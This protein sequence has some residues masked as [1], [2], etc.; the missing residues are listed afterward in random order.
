MG[1]G[2]RWHTH[3]KY[4]FLAA[5]YAGIVVI[6]GLV[7]AMLYR[8]RV[9]VYPV[10]FAAAL[11]FVLHPVA[12]WLTRHR[13][14]RSV[15][16]AIVVFLALVAAIALGFLIVPMLIVR[17]SEVIER[18]PAMVRT[19]Q[20]AVGPFLQ[21]NLGVEL[22]ADPAAI[23]AAVQEHL[24]ELAKPSGWLISNIFRSA[25][26]IGLA[27][28][29]VVITVVFTFYIVRNHDDIGGR[30]LDLIPARYRDRVLESFT[31]I[32]EALS[33]FVRG[34]IMVCLIMA[35]VYGTVLTVIG[36]QG[37]GVIGVLAGVANFVPYLGIV[38]GITLSL[39][40]VL[41]DAGGMG[42]VIAVCA[43]FSAGPVL[44]SMFITPQIVGSRVGLN[45]FLVI[46]AMLAGG[47]LLGFLGLL[48][49]LPAAAVLRA[50]FKLWIRDYRASRFYLGDE[51]LEADD[52][53][54]EEAKEGGG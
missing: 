33:G 36:V 7:V 17:L 44:D 41:L 39:L 35:S 28:I 29:N 30:V 54:R 38:V 3:G 1:I 47:E 40:S 21:E 4:P 31:A 48:L 2:N 22:R 10:M 43:T 52:T 5:K 19:L 24:S 16:A 49:A 51:A 8:L 6:I 15:A 27:M 12:D 11:G 32:D 9:V 14:P 18:I 45:P 37:G 25:L 20:I 42:Q 23:G 26:N 50:L 34:Q 13:I 53:A 46:V